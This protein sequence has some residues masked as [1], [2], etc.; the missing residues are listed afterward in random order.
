MAFGSTIVMMENAYMTDD[1]WVEA[2]YSIVKEY[3]SMPFVA[4]NPDWSMVELLD[5]F[6]SHK[7]VL[8]ANEL[9]SDHNI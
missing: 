8:S 6:K 3:R 9:H 4:D 5:G 7:N 2:S 1:A